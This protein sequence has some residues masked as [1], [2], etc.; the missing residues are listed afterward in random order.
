MKFKQSIESHYERFGTSITNFPRS[1]PLPQINRAQWILIPTKLNSIFKGIGYIHCFLFRL[2]MAGFMGFGG[3]C[4]W[5]NNGRFS[6]LEWNR[7]V[8]TYIED[9]EWL[10][11]RFKVVEEGI[12]ILM[13]A[14]WGDFK[15][16]LMII[17]MKIWCEFLV[18]LGIWMREVKSD[19][20]FWS[21][22][23]REERCFEPRILVF[24]AQ[25]TEP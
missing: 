22:G 7:V 17:K 24:G 21:G 8:R 20:K 10:R 14:I 1:V 15:T 6:L 3:K 19:W 4:S 12:W 13:L 25:W 11:L 23:K 2:L 18:K 5:E 9:D 16:H